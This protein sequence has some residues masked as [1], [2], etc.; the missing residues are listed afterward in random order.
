VGWLIE[1]LP[2][3]YTNSVV[4]IGAVILGITAGVLGA[5]AVL[6]QRSLV[7]DAL[8]H[9]ALPGVAIAFLLAGAKDASSLAIG[10]G[11]ACL[12]GALFM[13]GIERTGR[14]RPDAAIGVVLAGFFSVGLVLLTYLANFN[15]A[16]QAGL[17]KYLFGQ[18][19]GL[20]ERD[21]VVMA[22]LCAASIALI[23]VGW[24]PLKTTLFDP[25]FAGSIGLPVRLL[26]VAMT[27][28]LVVGVIVGIRTVGAI[29][30]VAL[31]VV[32]T[33]T[34]RQLAD[35]LAPLLVLAGL[36]GAAVGAIG[37]L[38]SESAGLP[39]G[40]VIVLVGFGVAV[41]TVLLAPG[42]GVAW[43]ARRLLADR[44]RAA[45]EAVLVDLETA[46]HAGPP[47][48]A[49][50]LTLASGRSAAAIRRALRDLDRAGM[51]RRED[52]RVFLSESGA[53]AAHAVLERRELWSAW[54]EHGW[55]LELP[56]AR[57]PD[58]AD[59]RT[60]LGDELADRLQGLAAA[61]EPGEGIGRR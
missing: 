38:L 54:L 19:A 60:S 1:L 45:T 56:D 42:R 33:V 43:R 41:A 48:T 13:V 31:L 11:L 35:R 9:A 4:L 3:G 27:A 52:G 7:G 25:S 26:D 12:V 53:A 17:D 24:R 2:L 58:P 20:L 32:P 57:E 36:V 14:I 44:R 59:L 47:P 23:A 6:R 15:N 51:L 40:P 49:D 50:E 8:S 30:M 61:S 29:L 21:L 39:T 22:A 55:R 18:A 34:A 16:S 46:L 37:A 28:L 10:A 5:F